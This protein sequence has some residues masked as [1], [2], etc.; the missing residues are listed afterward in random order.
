MTRLTI[1]VAATLSDGIGQ[2]GRLPWRLSKELQYFAR[3]TSNAPEGSVNAVL[4]GRNTWESIPK[5]FRPLPKRVNVVIS[6]NRQYELMPASATTPAAPVFL[7]SNLDSTLDRL[8]HS[9]R[10][11]TPIHRAFV[12]GGASLYQETLS[13]SPSSGSYVDRVLLTRILEPAFEQCDVHMPNFLN[14]EPQRGEHVAWRRTSHA[15]LQEWAG[16]EV[17]EGVQEESGVKYE[18]QMWAR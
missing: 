8:S 10:L 6:S 13:L 2:N 12:I 3:V 4:M 5:K 14:A 7:H 1:I 17:P 15:E 11:E 16:F 18:F 9:E